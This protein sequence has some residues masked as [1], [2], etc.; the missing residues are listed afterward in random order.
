MMAWVTMH[1]PF[2]TLSRISSFYG[3][4]LLTGH[5]GLLANTSSRGLSEV[6]LC[7]MSAIDYSGRGSM[8]ADKREMIW[9]ELRAI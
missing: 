7:G 8:S 5:N 9:L 2:V 4:R 3:R 6:V 1:L